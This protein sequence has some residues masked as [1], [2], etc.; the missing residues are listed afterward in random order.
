MVRLKDIKEA[1]R[2]AFAYMKPGVIANHVMTADEYQADIDA[3]ALYAH[4]W[5]GGVLFLRKRERYHL[6]SYCVNDQNIFPDVELPAGTVTEIAYKPNGANA[7]KEAI[8]YWKQVGLK[9]VFER[10][11]L[12]RPG[13]LIYKPLHACLTPESKQH[14]IV[15]AG[16]QDIDDCIKLIQANF[17]PITGHIP[18]S[19]EIKASIVEGC[20]LCVKDSYSDEICG[21]LRCIHRAASVEIRQLALNEDVRGQGLASK[22]LDAFN[23]KWNEKKSTVWMRDGNMPALKAYQSAGFVT[24][25]WRANVLTN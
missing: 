17:D 2:L 16:N 14:R 11:R 21:L 23:E 15:L 12:T 3:G 8:Q 5:P 1:S 13:G 25:G 7:A 4:T 10:I 18:T 9:Q 6:L 20:I 24:D 19:R 22:L